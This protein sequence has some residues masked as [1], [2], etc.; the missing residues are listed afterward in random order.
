MSPSAFSFRY[1]TSYGGGVRAGTPLFPREPE[2]WNFKQPLPS[3]NRAVRLI[4]HSVSNLVPSNA[5]FARL[6]LA[7]EVV[8]HSFPIDQ[9][10]RVYLAPFR[11]LSLAGGVR[12]GSH[13]T[14]SQAPGESPPNGTC[15][16]TW[17]RA[18][19]HPRASWRSGRGL[20]EPRSGPH[21]TSRAT[22]KRLWW[23]WG[24]HRA[25]RE[26]NH[27]HSHPSTGSG[28]PAGEHWTPVVDFQPY[29]A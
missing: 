1:S 29:I 6:V 24:G 23:G 19:V 14:T 20:W 26:E 4:S 17:P 18:C 25:T 28:P 2:S 21:L 3:K 15:A 27:A 9:R 12:G 10:Q 5:V 7:D 16:H 22:G 13:P 11:G 8:V